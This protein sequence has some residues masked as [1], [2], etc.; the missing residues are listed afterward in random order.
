MHVQGDRGASASPKKTQTM[1]GEHLTGDQISE[2]PQPDSPKYEEVD[3]HESV[4]T[5]G[6]EK[7]LKPVSELGKKLQNWRRGAAAEEYS[8][9]VDHRNQS[10]S[11]PALDSSGMD[12][13]QAKLRAVKKGSPLIDQ[14]ALGQELVKLK[15]A[16]G[17]DDDISDQRVFDLR[18]SVSGVRNSVDTP[19]VTL[20]IDLEDDD[21]M[22]PLSTPLGK[23]SRPNEDSPH[24]SVSPRSVS[25]PSRA[26]S[27]I[28]E[29]RHASP[30]SE[31]VRSTRHSDLSVRH[32]SRR[33]SV[34]NGPDDEKMQRVKTHA[35]RKSIFARTLEE[36]GLMEHMHKSSSSEPNLRSK[37]TTSPKGEEKGDDEEMLVLHPG[38]PKIRKPRGSIFS[39]GGIHLN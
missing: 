18:N 31:P 24:S 15:A 14:V 10:S 33:Y 16:A 22:S 38:L 25:Y 11:P 35:K 28:V 4:A 9:L 23:G 3:P 17:A 1:A 20:H 12:S 7:A 27:D 8:S 30:A 37:A 32:L 19:D 34:S 5:S 21:K 29:G 26:T 6:L 36:V 2:S 39:L 13:P